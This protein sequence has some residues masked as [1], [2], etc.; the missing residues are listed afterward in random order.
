METTKNA[1]TTAR[2]DPETGD[3][4]RLSSLPD[5]VL[6]HILSFMET[7]YAVS[8][9]VLSRRWEDLWTRVSSL[10]LERVFTPQLLIEAMSRETDALEI[11]DLEF[12]RLVNKVMGQHKDL[13]SVRRLR[14]RFTDD[15][16]ELFDKGLV[17]GPPMEEIDVKIHGCPGNGS[18]QQ[19]W[20]CVPENFYT[21]KNL[22]VAKLSGVILG[23]INESVFLPSLKIL[24]LCEVGIEDFESLGRFISGCPA[25]ENAHL[26]SCKP[27]NQSEKA[28]IEVSL[29][30]LKS[31]VI[32]DDGNRDGP[33]CPIVMEAPKLEDLHLREFADL[34]F[35]GITPLPCLHTAD[36]DVG[37]ECRTSVHDLIRL[38]AGISNAKTMVLSR[39]TLSH[40]SA[41][42]DDVQLPVFPNLAHLTIQIGG[43]SGSSWVLHAL[44]NSASKLQSLV[45]VLGDTIG[46]MGMRW[47]NLETARTPECLLSSLEEIEIQELQVC[48]E[49]KKMIAYLLKA[50][51]VLKKVNIQGSYSDL[52]DDIDFMS[53]PKLPRGSSACTI[54]LDLIQRRRLDP[55]ADLRHS[56]DYFFEI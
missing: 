54:E 43:C 21:L 55:V 56:W 4:D 10:D 1:S 11:R 24:Q 34:H 23:A 2:A 32:K 17:F 3:V 53:L 33:M 12:C 37:K 28:M 14:F 49:E 5:H 47:E 51:A 8:T 15:H 40:L 19:R 41:V 46:P 27:S 31:L 38:L 39:H 26:E 30:C 16:G 52:A 45:I 7:K 25:L 48:G 44:L 22:K 36:V 35:K 50:G 9:A 13:N 20:R 29:P 42:D 18:R 6:S